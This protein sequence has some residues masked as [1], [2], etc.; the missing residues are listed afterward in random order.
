MN[1]SWR[2]VCGSS[3]WSEPADTLR[4]EHLQNT[5]Y[6]A[7]VA[8]LANGAPV[9]WLSDTVLFEHGFIEAATNHFQKALSAAEVA[10]DLRAVCACQL[11]LMNLLADRS[12]HQVVAPLLAQVRRNVTQVGDATTTAALHIGIAEL[13]AKRGFTK[14]RKQTCGACQ[15][16][17]AS[18]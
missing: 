4:A 3:Y 2:I 14:Y 16:P 6:G 11:R 9:S 12:G 15:E 7:L 8:W 13:E 18:V 10:G 1:D 5:Y 17:S